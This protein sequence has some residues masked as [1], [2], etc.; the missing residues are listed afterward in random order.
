MNLNLAKLKILN[1]K[2]LR[3]ELGISTTLMYKFRKAGMPYHQLP[4]GRAYYYIDEVEEWLHNVGL[5]KEVIWVPE[6]NKSKI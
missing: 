5:H 3:E 1:G 4:E 6:K 2:D